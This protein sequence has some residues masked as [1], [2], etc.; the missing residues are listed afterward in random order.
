MTDCLAAPHARRVSRTAPHLVWCEQLALR[1]LLRLWRLQQQHT[2][3]ASS[4]RGPTG[5]RAAH[6]CDTDHHHHHPQH[7]LLRFSFS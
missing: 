1:Q 7:T 2:T 4:E 3:R 5:S 6:W